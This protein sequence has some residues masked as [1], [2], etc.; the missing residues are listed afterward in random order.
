MT[1]RLA[2]LLQEPAAAVRA[3]WPDPRS[4]LRLRL[5]VLLRRGALDRQLSDGLAA[6]GSEDRALRARQLG[7]AH[8]RRRL[9][10]SLRGLIEDSELP[11]T[12]RLSAA[13]PVCRRAVLPCRQALLGLA[14]RLERTD[15]VNPCGVARVRVLLTDGGSPVYDPHPARSMSDAIWWIADGLG[16]SRAG[17]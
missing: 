17:R 10:R 13:V 12:E 7:D 8:T 9:A 14:E 3:G 15:P 2:P 4:G 5:R 6:E 16:P 11:A 1:M